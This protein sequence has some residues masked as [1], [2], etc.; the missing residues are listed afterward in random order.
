M[1]DTKHIPESLAVFVGNANGRGLIRIEEENT[2]KHIASAPRGE[3]SEKIIFEIARRYDLHTEL[4]EALE[5]AVNGLE[6]FM[7]TWQDGPDKMDREALEKF[8]AAIAKARGQ[9]DTD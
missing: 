8:N 1:T 3:E 7:D 2:G 9:N 6:W 4:L 5:E